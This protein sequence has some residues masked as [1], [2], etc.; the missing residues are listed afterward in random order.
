[1]KTKL[2]IILA[3]FILGSSTFAQNFWQKV[4]ELNY[5]VR[6]FAFDNS[7]NIYAGT[8]GAGVYRSSNNGDNWV[9]MNNGL[10]DLNVFSIVCNSS[11][12][13]FAGTS[14][15]GVFKSTDNG[16]TWNNTSLNTGTVYSLASNSSGYIFAGSNNG[17]YRS[18]DN[19]LNWIQS[20]DSLVVYNIVSKDNGY[21]IALTN[22]QY[23]VFRSPDNGVTWGFKE[24]S[25]NFNYFGLASNG[26]IFATTGGEY[27]ELG[28]YLHS[29][30]DDA[31][32]WGYLY[33][34]GSASQRVAVN[35]SGIVFVSRGNGIWVSNTSGMSGLYQNSG[36]NLNG[37]LILGLKTSLGGNVFAGQENGY[38]YRDSSSPT[39]IIPGSNIPSIFKLY[40]NYPN[41]FNPATKIKF[42][43]PAVETTRRVVSTKILVYDILGRE[44]AVLV[45]ENLNPGTYEI[46]W[47]G[48]NF[49][50]GIYY[51]SLITSEFNESKKM[52]LLK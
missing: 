22:L 42:Q 26:V 21:V 15:H 5:P 48:S 3:S 13:V 37:G 7:G 11:G 45:N 4:A 8:V 33:N 12:M 46:E 41:P 32:S 18:F 10:N 2:F 17:I 30:S 19:G 24:Q 29:S 23:K 47:D 9:Q 43:I 52:I 34:F 27:D 39:G 40:Q 50:S 44:I 14:S 51:Y 38:V 28:F 16:N 20:L 6:S 31:N 36:L 1:M 49:S 25:F 35:N